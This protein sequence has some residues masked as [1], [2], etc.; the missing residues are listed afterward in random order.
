MGGSLPYDGTPCST[1]QTMGEIAKLLRKRGAAE[2]VS[3]ECLE[4]AKVAAYQVRFQLRGRVYR[5]RVEAPADKEREQRRLLRCLL[6]GI[7]GMLDLEA[8]GIMRFEDVGLGFL[9]LQDGRGTRATVAELIGPQI[10]AGMLP[11]L[12]EGLKALPERGIR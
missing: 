5:F 4:S 7:K 6:H 11:S 8:L 10:G 1:Q 12:T 3:W 2:A 9:E